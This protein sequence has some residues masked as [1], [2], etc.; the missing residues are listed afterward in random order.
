[1]H[2]AQIGAN[3]VVMVPKDININLLNYEIII[4]QNSY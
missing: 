1:M 2:I 3:I 4:V